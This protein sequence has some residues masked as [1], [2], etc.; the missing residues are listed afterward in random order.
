VP[1]PRPHR[2]TGCHTCGRSGRSPAGIDALIAAEEDGR[3]GRPGWL[4]GDRQR[5]FAWVILS[6]L[7]PGPSRSSAARLASVSRTSRSRWPAGTARR[8]P[9]STTW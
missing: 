8:S 2:Y 5:S 1:A 7:P 9:R 3:P 4:A 6:L